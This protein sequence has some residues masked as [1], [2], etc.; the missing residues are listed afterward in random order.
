MTKTLFAEIVAAGI[1]HDHHE[2][3]LYLPRT[4]AVLEILARH[5]LQKSNATSF[6]NQIDGKPWLD[7]PFAFQPF[8]DKVARVTQASE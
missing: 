6:R 4:A 5:P 2:S 3:D 1:E 8:W 7:V